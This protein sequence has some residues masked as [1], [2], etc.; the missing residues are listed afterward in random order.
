VTL[1]A[2][3]LQLVPYLTDALS[4][5]RDAYTRFSFTAS[6]EDQAAIGTALDRLR[7][8]AT[9]TAKRLG[10]EEAGPRLLSAIQAAREALKDPDTAK[11]EL[12]ELLV[13]MQKAIQATQLG[14]S[15]EMSH[16]TTQNEDQE[17]RLGTATAL[18]EAALLVDALALRARSA[19]QALI[20]NHNTAAVKTITAITGE[21]EKSTQDLFY[22]V[23]EPATNQKIGA[24]IAQIGNYKQGLDRLLAAEQKQAVLVHEVDAATKAA[25]AE[26]QSLTD[27][28]L[29]AMDQEHRRA[30]LLLGI[31]VGLALVVGVALAL[32]IGRGISRPLQ[33][34][35]DVMG[36][37]AGG[38]KTVEIP[39]RDRRDEFRQVA[40]AVA[41]F[42]DN[43]LAMDQMAEE[44]TASDSRAEAEKRQAVL[45][46][47]DSLDS[48]VSSVV[49]SIGSAAH[50][51]QSTATGLTSTAEGTRRQA[52]AAADASDMARANVQ[53]VAA[54][55][56]E[57]SVSIAEISRQ[58]GTSVEMVSRAVE[59]SNHTNARVAK[60]S[61]A[62]EKIETVVALIH[63]IASRTNLLALNAT[64]EA[65]HAGAAGVGFA[66]VA[67]EV[68]QLAQQTAKATSEI[69]VQIGAIQ[70]ATRESVD[71]IGGISRTIGEMGAITAAISEAVEQQGLATTAIARNIQD[72]AS[73]T[74]RATANIA[75]VSDAARQTGDAADAV[76]SAAAALATDSD[77]LRGQVRAFLQQVVNG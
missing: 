9:G 28:Q 12:P 70:Q 4:G 58:V 49:D 32:A 35:A 26:A 5:V 69:A 51:L 7:M 61:E 14:F 54:A 57:L 15:N 55:A 16:T 62:A 73:G 25:I 6:P 11:A 36:R 40:A 77:K 41:V 52:T 33:A 22:R 53:A 38:D 31:G 23:T 37:L 60:L 59:D 45:Q 13:T 20:F 24:L 46:L 50:G 56:E 42:R 34:L 29:V 47:A 17:S 64:I 10:A 71:A 21:I 48:I 27:A 19:E 30:D 43:A 63:Q 66:V 74:S 1:A 39:G 65:A 72:A 3:S 44:R 18:R 2:T 67:S 68:K 76:L 75:S 8:M